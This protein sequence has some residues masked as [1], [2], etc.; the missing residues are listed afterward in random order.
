MIGS[1]TCQGFQQ[2][3]RCTTMHQP[4]RLHRALIDGHATAQEVHSH[5]NHFN[6]KMRHCAVAMQGIER[7]DVWRHDPDWR[8]Q[9]LA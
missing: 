7:S 9:Q 3:N 1:G 8:R 4:E 2:Q 5:L 6:A